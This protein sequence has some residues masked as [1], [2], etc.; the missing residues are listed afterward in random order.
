MITKES[1]VI[2]LDHI[3]TIVKNDIQRAEL[4]SKIFPNA[5]QA[6][7]LFDGDRT[8]RLVNVLQDI[9]SDEYE[10]ISYFCW[11]LDFGKKSKEIECY[12]ENGE[13]IDLS[14]PESLYDFLV[15]DK[16]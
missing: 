4:F 3:K 2:L 9:M 14:C 6:N 13:V 7:L 8:Q 12:D 10:W 5:F 11:E 1:F 15:K 16:G